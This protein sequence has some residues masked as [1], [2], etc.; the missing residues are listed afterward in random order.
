ML[1]IALP[2][3]RFEAPKVVA[4]SMKV[5]VP[6]TRVVGE[7]TFAVNVTVCPT[8]AGLRED[9]KAVVVVASL[10][11]SGSAAAALLLA[12]YLSPLYVAVKEWLVAVSFEVLMVATPL[13]FR[14]PVPTTTLPSLNVTVPVGGF[15]PVVVT[16]ELS[17]TDCP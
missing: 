8:L 3:A 1:N 11:T 13:V 12:L 15:E 2:A 7:V 4:P 5:T 10:T 9:F 14:V 16:W 6:V 17:V